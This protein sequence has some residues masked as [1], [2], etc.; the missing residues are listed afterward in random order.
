[1]RLVMRV[2]NG[3]ILSACACYLV[4]IRFLESTSRVSICTLVLFVLFFAVNVIPSPQNLKIKSTK[5]RALAEGADLLTSYLIATTF[6]TAFYIACLIS[7]AGILLLGVVGLAGSILVSVLLLGL[8]FWNG[9]LRVCFLS[10]Q[11]KISQKVLGVL[12][13][14]IP[15]IN[16]GALSYAITTATKEVVF[17]S[18]K[19]T[20]NTQRKHKEIC[21]TRYP[22]LL[23]HGVFFRDFKH[24]NYWGRIPDELIKNGAKIYYG[25]HHSA[26]SVTDSGVELTNRIKEIADKTGCGKVNIIAHSKGGLDCRYAI[27]KCGADKYVASLT[28]INTPHKGCVFADYLLDRIPEKTKNSVALTYNS[29]MKK[30][31]DSNPSFLDAV[32][33]LTYEKCA[34][35]NAETPD[36]EGIFYQ[37]VGS[38]LNK[39]TGGKFPLNF[40][41]HLVNYFDGANDGLVA[42]SSFEWGSN[43]TFVTTKGKRG[44]SHGD[45]IDLNR[46][47]IPEFD[48]REFYVNLVGDL[49]K[50]GL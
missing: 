25:N 17:E 14:G 41:Y 50:K 12:F 11:L 16:I 40:S 27:S 23:V 45:M 35:F 7:G 21:K 46:E 20:L 43:F 31:G 15:F 44:I 28:T 30:L 33:D 8:T 49:K 6:V 26:S 29:A 18:K 24:F 13:G 36:K 39:A 2:V 9:I 1:M 3:I 42:E 32:T 38:K 22:I 48:V 19:E 10:R 47:N 5:F 37:S 34:K 4:I